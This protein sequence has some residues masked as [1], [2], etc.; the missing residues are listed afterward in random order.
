MAEENTT[1]SISVASLPDDILAIT[2]SERHASTLNIDGQLMD[3][4]TISS[5]LKEAK[6]RSIVKE[7]LLRNVQVDELVAEGMEE[8]FQNSGKVWTKTEAIHCTGL[9]S[10]MIRALLPYTSHFGFTGNVPIAHNPRYGLDRDSLEALGSQLLSQGDHHMNNDATTT[11]RGQEDASSLRPSLQTLSIKGT[12]LTNPG[13]SCFCEGIRASKSLSTLQLSSC[14]LEGEDVILLA[15]ALRENQHLKS[16]SLADCRF[17]NVPPQDSSMPLSDGVS[18]DESVTSTS[19]L[20][21]IA[22]GETIT[23]STNNINPQSHFPILLEAL[24]QHP[25]LE[26]LNIFGM[27]CNDL[28]MKA[29]GDMLQFPY[30]KLWH[31]GLKNNLSHPEDKVNVSLLLQA[32]AQNTSLTYLKVSGANLNDDDVSEIARILADCNSTLHALSITDNAFG[33][34]GLL[35]FA[36]RLADMKGLR[37]LDVQRNPITISSKKAIVSALKDNAEI[38]RLDLD[39]TL[40]AKKS[41]WLCLNRAGRRLLSRADSVPTS[42]WPIILERASKLHYGRNQYSINYDVMYY[43]LRR[44]PWLFEIATMKEENVEDDS[45]KRLYHSISSMQGHNNISQPYID[46]NEWDDESKPRAKRKIEP[47]LAVPSKKVE[48]LARTPTS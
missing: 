34:P 33:D 39:G 8:L 15:S 9:I 17:G 5:V 43:M 18:S 32:L 36:H 19:S 23:Q 12:R 11:T 1:T 28:S 41:W 10:R 29:L 44:M 4:A 2:F 26:A 48:T 6:N 37:Y 24:V 42:L 30:S 22:E 7:L 27:C 16:F 21:D 35:S 3:S 31:L 46:T 38:E 20:P 25:A 40:D 13:F 47:I 14:A 45:R